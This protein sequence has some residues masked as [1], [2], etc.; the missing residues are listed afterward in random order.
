MSQPPG[1]TAEIITKRER[2]YLLAKTKVKMKSSLEN[3]ELGDYSITNFQE[4]QVVEVPRWLGEE[5]V[6]LKLAEPQEEPFE[7]EVYRALSREK[8]LGP[9]QLSQ[10]SVEFYM[11]MRRKLSVLEGEVAQGTARKEDLDRLRSSCYDLVGM[12]LS[13]MLSLSSSSA[14]PGTLADK[15]TPEESAFFSL[16]QSLSKEWKDALLGVGR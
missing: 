8:M 1:S 15:L 2:D 5:L 4:G 9:L 14:P 13:K 6:L 7:T 10:L 12:R 3:I 11:R 16:S